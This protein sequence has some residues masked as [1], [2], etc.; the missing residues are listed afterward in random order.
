ML[1]DRSGVH[2]LYTPAML[3]QLL[4]VPIA[5]VRRWHRRGL[6][7]PA[8]TVR[9]L[10]YFDFS[11]IAAARRL[12]EL[13]ASGVS[14]Q[15]IEKQLT[16]LGRLLPGFERSI[17]QLSIIVDGKDLLL[18]QGEG[19]IDHR[20]QRRIDFEAD[21]R[22]LEPVVALA[23]RPLPDMAY[24]A[25]HGGPTAPVSESDS[26]LDAATGSELPHTPQQLLALAAELEDSE[27]LPAAIDMVR[28]ALAAG[29]P[30]AEICFQLAELLYRQGQVA[31]AIERYY[32]AI[33]LDEDYV[34]ARANLGCALAEAGQLDL[35]A[36]AFSG[37]LLYHADYA[38]AH[39][40]LARTLDQLGRPDEAAGHWRT[41]EE[42][43]PESPWADEA[44]L[45]MGN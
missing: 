7:R 20:G 25:P 35:A 28:A 36:A 24:D 26:T 13:L 44:R 34:E 29:G 3:A 1:P 11:E 31:A 30:T 12:A 9:K 15:A 21:E 23:M 17:A 16:A 37:A 14:P 42:L 27:Q 4:N 40:H 43:S 32:M 45:R 8:H 6:I 39:Y 10:P 41:F 33:E 2:Q 19:L 38:D 22:A 18:R 5:V